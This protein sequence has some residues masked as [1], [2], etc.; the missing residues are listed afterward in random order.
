MLKRIILS[1]L[2]ITSTLNV[3][4]QSMSSHLGGYDTL[5]LED[6]MNIKITVASTTELTAKESPA[7]VSTITADDIK[8]M[9]ANDLMDVLKLVPGFQFGVDVEG[10]VGL[11][12]RGNWS[13]EGKVVLLYDGQ[14]L[15]EGLYSTLQFGNHYPV[16]NIERIEI[17]RGP[18]S[19]MYGGYAAH[20]VINVVTRTAKQA[21]EYQASARYDISKG[22]NTGKGINLYGGIKTKTGN[23]FNIQATQNST[24]RSLE[25]Y[26]D[27]F[28]NFYSMENES[29]IHNK[30]VNL[31]ASISGIK[32]TAIIDEYRINERDEYQE[33][34]PGNVPL[35]FSNFWGELKYDWQVNKQLKIS[36]KIN[37]KRQSPWK[38]TSDDTLNLTSALFDIMSERISYNLNSIYTP[39]SKISISGG[40]GYFQDRSTQNIESEYFKSNNSKTLSYSNFAIYGQALFQILKMNLIAGCR[41]NDNSRFEST[42]VPRIGIT[43]SSEKYHIKALYSK[44]FRSPSTLNIDLGD[45]IRPEVTDVIELEGGIKTDENGYLTLNVF[46]IETKDPIIYYFNETTSSDSYINANNTG[47]SGFELEYKYKKSKLT[48]TT[49]LSYYTTLDKEEM[50]IFA[51][52]EQENSHIGIAPIKINTLIKYSI[53]NEVSGSLSLNYLSERE[54]ISKVDNTSN[55]IETRKYSSYTELN[56]FAEYSPLSFKQLS[57]SLGCTNLL[58]QRS[59]FIQPYN[60]FHGALPGLGRNFQFKIT[61]QNF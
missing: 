58:D 51:F 46:N 5:S 39:T 14:E 6:L 13:H 12:V 36:P 43:K 17:I 42:L 50:S 37:Y 56:L 45:K 49:S 55:Q 21:I 48:S 28:G 26:Y 24:Q 53:S 8:A 40:A 59:Y 22:T 52:E 41:Y 61:L 29:W 7:I 9:G 32:A 60:N 33:I 16:Q 35:N 25:K 3:R 18:G 2:I 20:A 19:S 23:T 34:A 30:Y 44:S 47:S 10:V 4:G 27:V 31:N 15:N 57:F 11:A 54:G 38:Y 1:L